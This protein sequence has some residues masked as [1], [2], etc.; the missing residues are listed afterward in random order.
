MDRLTRSGAALA[1]WRPADRTVGLRPTPASF[2][3]RQSGQAESLLDVA[4]EQAR[5]VGL[6]PDLRSK[7]DY[8]LA[9]VLRLRDRYEDAA[10]RFEL[11]TWHDGVG[12]A[13]CLMS[14]GAAL[15]DRLRAALLARA[16]TGAAP[17]PEE[18]EAFVE[19]AGRIREGLAAL[20][21][22]TEDSRRWVV[23]LL[24][25]EAYT[26]LALGGETVDAERAVSA[27]EAE[28]QAQ[29]RTSSDR[30]LSFVQALLAL[31]SG[32]T[33]SALSHVRSCEEDY[34]DTGLDEEYGDV[35]VLA[36][37]VRWEA[38]DRELAERYL[39]RAEALPEGTANGPAKAFVARFR[40]EQEA[41]RAGKGTWLF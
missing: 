4:L 32:D 37:R 33:E 30:K 16:R 31:R 10:R 1:L 24:A 15:A 6:S 17:Q 8:E 18:R 5:A 20:Q 14:R 35:H 7:L 39:D 40:Q 41:F 26:Q 28:R 34:L 27:W 19:E 22:P 2:A 36:A 21:P 3:G 25:H 23:N 12:E 11:S 9:Y 38:G 29:G 13:A